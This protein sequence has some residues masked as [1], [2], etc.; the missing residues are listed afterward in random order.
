[1]KKTTNTL[2]L[3]LVAL[4]VN[5]SAATSF[6]ADPNSLVG[7]EWD[8][9]LTEPAA[10]T[11]TY[12]DPF[13]DP[14]QGATV[15]AVEPSFGYNQGPAQTTFGTISV[16]DSLVTSDVLDHYNFPGGFLFNPDS[17]YIHNGAFQWNTSITLAATVD[18][19]RVSYALL[20]FG[21]TPAS[22]FDNAPSIAG[23]TLLDS[24]SYDDIT[25]TV[26]YYDF[27][28]A[29][30]STEIDTTFGDL[31]STPFAPGFFPGSFKS[32]DAIQVEGLNVA[33]TAIP[34]PSA[35]LLGL[36]GTLGLLR[37]RR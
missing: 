31:I 1:M 2:F 32:I 11:S 3:G 24:G 35:A 16:T 30:S 29:S 9:W 19:V 17:Y 21:G 20:G 34:E 25:S 6:I 7:A 12:D 33:P 18:Y 5:A 13:D 15:T 37:R 14:D 8:F 10:T 36:L 26:F 22:A 28:L 23:A 4:A 27:Q